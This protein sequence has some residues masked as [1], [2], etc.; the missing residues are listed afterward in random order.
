MAKA[1]SK[2][3]TTLKMLGLRI[4]KLREA[5]GLNQTELAHRCNKD[6]QIISLLELGRSNP[7]VKTLSLIAQELNV[8]IAELF[9]F[10]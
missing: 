9:R 8:P 1:V 7:T 6:R 4:A 2:S 10:D 3:D 5:A